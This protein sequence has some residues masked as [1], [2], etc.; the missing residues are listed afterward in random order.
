LFKNILIAYD[1]STS[2]RKALE[3]GI[4]MAKA[5][6][7]RLSIVSVE[8]NIPIVAADIGEVKEEKQFFNGYF[9]KLQRD[10]REIV[11]S[12][13]MDLHKADILTG[14]VSKS[15][16]NYSKSIKSDLVILGHSGR[17]GAWSNFLGTTAEKVSRHAD[18]TV[19]I[20]R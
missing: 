17:S 10:A 13:E 3:T 2:S 9:T 14:H 11:K 20:V 4:G 18:C 8:E 19:M 6:A 12:H 7:S 15:I 5:F 1:G 16:I